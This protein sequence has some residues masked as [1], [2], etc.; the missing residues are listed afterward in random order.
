M[1]YAVWIDGTGPVEY[2]NVWDAVNY[3]AT[4]HMDGYE[5]LVRDTVLGV[6]WSP[7]QEAS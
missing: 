4:W 5:V 7:M 1:R 6:T 3:A 2:A